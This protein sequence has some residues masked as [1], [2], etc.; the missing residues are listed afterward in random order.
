LARLGR[1]Y[2]E[3]DKNEPY[4]ITGFPRCHTPDG[5][6]IK[7]QG[8]GT[9][10]YTAL[11][12]GAY[13]E[14]HEITRISMYGEGNGVSSWTANRSSEADH[15]WAAAVNTRLAEQEDRSET[16]KEE[17]VEL[18]LSPSDLDRFIDDGE[19]VYVNKVSVDIEK[20]VERTAEFYPYK[21]ANSRH[22]IGAELVVKAGDAVDATGAMDLLWRAVEDN[23]DLII[24]VDPVTLQAFDVT[25]LSRE[26]MNLLAICAYAAEIDDA[27]ISEMWRRN[28]LGLDPERQSSGRRLAE[29]DDSV[30]EARRE[31]GWS[32]LEDLP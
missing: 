20:T 22:L 6:Q 27:L 17:D 7:R 13:M 31:A 30:L 8:W 15:W 12:L 28:E 24:E 21:N 14:N 1:G 5:V 11:C 2:Y 10:L 4:D 9:S 3:E 19:V 23:A 18:E 16:E 32:D 29:I 26:G 25:G